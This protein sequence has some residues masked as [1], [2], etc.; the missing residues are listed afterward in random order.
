MSPPLIA[1]PDLCYLF[2]DGRVVSSGSPVRLELG[3][4]WDRERGKYPDGQ[5]M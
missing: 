5:I 2:H 3:W 4:V 1:L